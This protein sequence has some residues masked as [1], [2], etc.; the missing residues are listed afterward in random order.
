MGKSGS[1][2]GLKLLYINGAPVLE[3]KQVP[4]LACPSRP[5]TEA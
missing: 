5:P 2:V 4:L 3:S 1:V